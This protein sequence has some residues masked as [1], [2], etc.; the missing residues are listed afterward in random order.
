MSLLLVYIC[1]AGPS[2]LLIEHKNKQFYIS[3]HRC[4][5]SLLKYQFSTVGEKVRE[6]STRR[7]SLCGTF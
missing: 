7:R 4:D 6:L 5:F 1:G 2:G 3:P